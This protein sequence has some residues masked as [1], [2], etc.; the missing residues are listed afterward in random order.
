MNTFLLV[1]RGEVSSSEKAEPMQDRR[2]RAYT[3]PKSIT[4]GL[5]TVSDAATVSR[6]L[7]AK[8]RERK[9]RHFFAEGLSGRTNAVWRTL[10]LFG[11]SPI[12]P[13]TR[14]SSRSSAFLALGKRFNSARNR[15]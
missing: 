6:S 8:R 4:I 5:V 3:A 1:D 15:I 2:K 12:H 11:S 7:V 13:A 9:A 10:M 14:S